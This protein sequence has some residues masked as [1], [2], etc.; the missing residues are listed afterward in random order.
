MGRQRVEALV[1]AA[2]YYLRGERPRCCAGP[3]S[4]VVKQ[5]YTEHFPFGVHEFAVKRFAACLALRSC[6]FKILGLDLCYL[7]IIELH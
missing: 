6:F 1:K 4:L 7:S 5:R 2:K 3:G